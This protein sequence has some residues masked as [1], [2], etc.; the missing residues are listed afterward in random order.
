MCSMSSVAITMSGVDF[1]RPKI[2]HRPA[3]IVITV[4]LPRPLDGIFGN[5]YAGTVKSGSRQCIGQ[6]PLTTAYFTKFRPRFV[7]DPFS[8][9]LC[10][11]V[12]AIFLG[13]DVVQRIGHMQ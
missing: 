4:P 3:E 8:E 6:I 13:G 10:D 7:R 1:I 2:I 11:R 12:L 5:I 9:Y